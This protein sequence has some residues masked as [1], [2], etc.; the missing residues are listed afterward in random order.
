LTDRDLSAL[1]LSARRRHTLAVLELSATLER[2]QSLLVRVN[3]DSALFAAGAKQLALWHSATR[4]THCSADLSGWLSTGQRHHCR[5]CGRLFCSLHCAFFVPID[6]A[7]LAR[8]TLRSCEHCFLLSKRLRRRCAFAE[9]R[10]GSVESERAR[11]QTCFAA[12]CALAVEC[13]AFVSQLEHERLEAD[14][15]ADADADVDSSPTLEPILSSAELALRE[16]ERR[17]A[18]ADAKASARLALKE[19][20]HQACRALIDA[21]PPSWSPQTIETVATRCRQRCAIK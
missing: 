19:A 17:S 10:R 3:G 16:R 8:Q 9:Q 6:A 11:L 13:D 12:F 14:F 5:F 1:F 15:A 4:C 21:L 2:A 7:R 18:A 20:L